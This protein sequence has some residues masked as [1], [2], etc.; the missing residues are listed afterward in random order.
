MKHLDQIVVKKLDDFPNSF[1]K[2]MI[3]AVSICSFGIIE[4]SLWK[5]IPIDKFKKDINEIT[6]ENIHFVFKVFVSYLLAEYVCNKNIN[7]KIYDSRGIDK[8]EIVNKIFVLYD[9]SK[10]DVDTFRNILNELTFNFDETLSGNYAYESQQKM[11]AESNSKCSI[12]ITFNKVRSATLVY[13]LILKECFNKNLQLSDDDKN[14]ENI[15]TFTIYLT[16]KADV[17][18]EILAKINSKYK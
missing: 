15:F 17:Y 1:I 14:L 16:N 4:S 3:A 13:K 11:F 6:V 10:E 12:K 9:Y 8:E 5:G 7:K 2:E 18:S